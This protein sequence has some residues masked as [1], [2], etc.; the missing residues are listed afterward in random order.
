MFVLN[1][2][3]VPLAPLGQLLSGDS[4]KVGRKVEEC[5]LGG[6]DGGWLSSTSSSR[7]VVVGV[8]ATLMQATPILF[9]RSLPCLCKL[10]IG[11]LC[12]GQPTIPSPVLDQCGGHHIPPSL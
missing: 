4:L 12:C 10:G 9:L 6:H 2:A 8:V 3:P 7:V 11:C 5:S 1:G